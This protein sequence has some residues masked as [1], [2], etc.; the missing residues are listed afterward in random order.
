MDVLAWNDYLNRIVYGFPMKLVFLLV[1]AYLVIFQVRWFSAPLR[2][3]RV[4]FSETF[5]AIRE[6]TYGFGGQITPFQATMVALSAT[7][8][9]GH[10]LGMLAAVLVGGPGAV[11]WMWLGYFFGT[12]TKFAE[13]TLAV[14]FRRRYTDGSVSG[15]PMYYL[16]RGLPRL[17]FLGYL[18]AFFAAVAAFGIGN[19][20]QAGAVGGALAPLGAPPALVGLFLALLVGVILGGGIVR[21]ARFAQV[22]VPL[23]L[24]LFLLAILPLF[25]LYAGQIP[26]A[27][28]LV[29][30]AAFSPEAALGGAA[31][32]SLFAAINA[33]LGRG[34]F[35]NEAG[36]GSAPIAH[37]QAQVDHPVRQGFWGVT[38]MFVSFLVTSLTALTFIASGLWRQG[39]SA[40]EAATA[41]F[42]AHPLGGVI[43]ALTVAVFALGTMV[44][45]GFYGEEAAAF[46]FGEGVR[47]PYR[48][49]FAVLA[50][51][52]PLGGLEAFLAISD[53]LNGL[54]AIPNLLG[55]ILLGPVV[56]RLTYG[57]FRG[58]PW[59]PPR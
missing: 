51:V 53:T 52:G 12:G 9:T 46:L 31:G 58:E 33:G 21:V 48:L 28:A 6:R 4:S 29:F 37:A 3:M 30:Q 7:V 35:A 44:S 49:T 34:I 17:R 27:L 43:L 47:W 40:A 23:K 32:Y 56:A 2:M 22:V 39:G 16:L 13:A 19:L 57:F 59:V 41:L 1:G 36:L 38:E 54:M 26:Q 8:G 11:F 42:Q 10:L 50:F 55:L 25:I 5:G 15:G 18:F 24:L 20:S 14:H 45:W